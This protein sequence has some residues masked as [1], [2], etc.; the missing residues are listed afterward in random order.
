MSAET[1]MSNTPS[2]GHLLRNRNFFFLWVA[3]SVSGIGD[4][5][6]HVGVIVTIFQRTGSALQASGVLV[7]TMIPVILL[8]PFAGTIVDHNSRKSVMIAMDFLR[9]GSVLLLLIFFQEESLSMWGVYSVIALL[10][11]ATTIY[12]PARQAILPSIVI[13]GQL[14]HANSIL[15]GTNQATLAAGFLLGGFLVLVISLPALVVINSLTLVISAVL[16]FPIKSGE[17]GQNLQGEKKPTLRESILNGVHYLRGHNLA[18]PLVIM[19]VMEHVPHGIWS[20]AIMLVFAEQALDGGPQ[21]WGVLASLYFGGQLFGAIIASYSARLLSRR[22]GWVII[23]NAG[24]FALLTII[25]SQSTTLIFASI[26][27]LIF[28]PPASIRDIAQESLLQKSVNESI[29]GRVYA[30]RSMLMSLVFMV[31]SIGFAY[32]ANYFSIRLIYLGGGILYSITALYALR[33]T[34]LR[35]TRFSDDEQLPMTVNP[36]S[37]V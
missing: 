31:S 14:V 36:S 3:Q 20:S 25:F 8:G 17:T 22:P 11:A 27:S 23:A 24:I 10:S 2:L 6:Y 4:V 16:T 5:I 9:G 1:T 21:T 28:G 7:A 12:R 29:L 15:V 26:V 30:F 18:R 37:T 13:P 35:N 34:A 33:S 19:E 32:L